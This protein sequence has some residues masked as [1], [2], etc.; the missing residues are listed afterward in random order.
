MER[1]DQSKCQDTEE[2]GLILTPCFFQCLIFFLDF[3]VIYLI[4]LDQEDE[5]SGQSQSLAGNVLY[6]TVQ[7]RSKTIKTTDLLPV[8]KSLENNT[9]K[10]FCEE[11]HVRKIC[12]LF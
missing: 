8:I 1:E 6:T 2:Q 11:Y 4:I 12:T 9:D 10:G 7:R 3:L 5:E